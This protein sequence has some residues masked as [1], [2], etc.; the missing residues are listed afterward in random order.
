MQ[1]YI[2]IFYD[3]L[4]VS[5]HKIVSKFNFEDFITLLLIQLFV[6]SVYFFYS[7]FIPHEPY[8]CMLFL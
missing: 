3:I 8:E 5:G 1:L 4:Y 2:K 6:Y 7:D